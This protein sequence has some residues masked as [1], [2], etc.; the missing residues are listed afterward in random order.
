MATTDTTTTPKSQPVPLSYI[1]GVFDSCGGI[2]IS[3]GKAD[4]W[5]GYRINVNLRISAPKYEPFFGMLDAF[6]EAND[7]DYKL[8]ER[9]DD[10]HQ[11]QLTKT[12]DIKTFLTLTNNHL[13][14]LVG[15]SDLVT[16]TIFPTQ[17]QGDTLDKQ[18]FYNLLST[19]ERQLPRRQ[20]NENVKYDTGFFE[21]EW[22]DSLSPNSTTGKIHTPDTPDTVDSAY[23]AGV[24][25]GRGCITPLVHPADDWSIGYSMTPQVTVSKMTNGRGLF[26]CIN[27]TLAEHDISAS[28]TKQSGK[29][30]LR[31]GGIE[32]LQSF[33]EF[34]H[35]DLV[36][37][38]T[39][40]QRLLSTVLPALNNEH[41]HTRQGFYDVLVEFH[42]LRKPR[43][44]RDPKYTPSYFEDEWSDALGA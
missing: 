5:V 1:A 37:R 42:S 16:D 18:G 24:I 28:V 10:I 33:F 30:T 22:E 20:D 14:Y 2:D 23:I 38:Y 43:K 17:E 7:I 3:V 9:T 29:R 8:K 34:I 40:S 13:V 39:D 36:L 26:D 19:V 41:H 12:D 35:D 27:R 15:K 32:N 21:D 11:W 31:I 6:C 44:G 25:D 4:R